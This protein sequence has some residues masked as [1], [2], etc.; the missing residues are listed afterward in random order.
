MKINE[1]GC[2]PVKLFTKTGGKLDLAHR[3]YS[4][5]PWSSK[6]KIHLQN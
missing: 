5:N 4:A 6:Q 1:Y 3:L 2:V